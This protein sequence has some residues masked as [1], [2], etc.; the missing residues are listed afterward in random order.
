MADEIEILT[1]NAGGTS[2]VDLTPSAISTGYQAQNISIDANRNGIDS[3]SIS[4]D[5]AT[6]EIVFSP[7]GLMDE[8]GL[9]FVAK[10][11]ARASL[12]GAGVYYIRLIAGTTSL[13]RS[14]SLVTTA[15]TYDAS[16][17]GFYESGDRVLDWVIYWEGSG[18][19][20]ITKR[21]IPQSG[22]TV[23]SIVTEKIDCSAIDCSAIDCSTID[24]SA[25]DSTLG[26]IVETYTGAI[27]TDSAEF[28]V[29][30][31][32]TIELELVTPNAVTADIVVAEIFTKNG[33][34]FE[35]NRSLPTRVTMGPGSGLIVSR[36]LVLMPGTHR[37]N[38]RQNVSPV[39]PTEDRTV[40]IRIL[41]AF[42]TTLK[43]SLTF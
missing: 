22:I 33:A 28:I 24:C 23:E 20:T 42:G 10:S 15:G 7:S 26:P 2:W 1:E 37:I 32:C 17:N 19:P 34:S 18:V 14:I 35:I 30:F 40:N 6:S 25:I 12:G 16:K 11:E 27:N 8:N 5:I 29:G 41:N 4:W 3:S 9:P 38:L 39:T 43:T 13:L 31:P 36:L 21:V